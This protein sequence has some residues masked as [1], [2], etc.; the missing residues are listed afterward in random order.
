VLISRVRFVNP[1]TVCFARHPDISVEIFE[2]AP[3]FGEVGAGIGVWPR[4]WRTLARLGLDEDLARLHAVRPT[5]DL[6][7]YPSATNRIIKM[8]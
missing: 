5:Y 7:L 2:Q 6:S 8:T 3:E 1:V 4:I